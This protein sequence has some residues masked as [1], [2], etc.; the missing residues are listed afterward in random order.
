[1]A[2]VTVPKD[3]THVKS[4]VVVLPF[5]NPIPHNTQLYKIMTTRL[6]EVVSQ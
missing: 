4:K 3:L 5:T 6:S 2:Y 1:M